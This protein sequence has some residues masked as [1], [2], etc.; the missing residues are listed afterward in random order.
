MSG[1]ERI[2]DPRTDFDDSNDIRQD[3]SGSEG[4][5]DNEDKV[6]MLDSS[7][8]EKTASEILSERSS[9]KLTGPKGVIA[10]Y[11]YARKKFDMKQAQTQS[12]CVHIPSSL[13]NEPVAKDFDEL[14]DADDQEF[15]EAYR[16]K[17]L[18]ELSQSTKSLAPREIFGEVY[19]LDFDSYNRAV[20]SANG[21][22][23]VIIHLHE[24]HIKLCQE[25]H[26]VFTELAG[27]YKYAKF[28]EIPAA[29]T[30]SKFDE[31]VLPTVLVYRGGKLVSNLVRFI[32][33]ISSPD[34]NYNTVE[35]VF[36]RLGVLTE[37][38]RH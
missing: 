28:C 27:T 37:F 23:P 21:D 7:T 17:R 36:L 6:K 2:L 4:F 32:D 9:G 5:S 24:F 1:L 15:F 26:S 22:V 11:R 10:D 29:A 35:G 8:Y 34:L 20:D 30:Q 18:Q 13:F 16:K 14:S 31:I 12:S 38:Q 25:L 33:E 3:E 19:Q